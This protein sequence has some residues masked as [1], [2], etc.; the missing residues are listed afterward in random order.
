MLL[1]L[2]QLLLLLLLLQA[3]A[4]AAA[5]AAAAAAATAAAAAAAAAAAC[6][7]FNPRMLLCGRV[8]QQ[9]IN[10]SDIVHAAHS[11]DGRADGI[12]D[13]PGPAV[14]CGFGY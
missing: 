14:D 5:A 8:Q 4:T 2:L 10:L 7:A 1:L 11:L 13:R 3:A 9:Q 12:Y 6:S